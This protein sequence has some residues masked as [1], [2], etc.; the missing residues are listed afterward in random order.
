M[1]QSIRLRVGMTYD[2]FPK[3]DNIKKRIESPKEPISK[4]KSQG[5][6][7]IIATFTGLFAKVFSD[8]WDPGSS[9]N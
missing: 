1:F 3:R 4:I 8:L 6:V 2:R 9:G 5:N 7:R